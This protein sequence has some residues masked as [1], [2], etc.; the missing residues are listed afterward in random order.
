M[1]RSDETAVQ[2]EPVFARH[3]VLLCDTDAGLKQAVEAAGAECIEMTS[4]HGKAAARFRDYTGRI[5]DAAKTAEGR[6]GWRRP[7][8]DGSL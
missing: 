3:I 2:T 4:R 7:H 6:D 1:D 5:G 8:P